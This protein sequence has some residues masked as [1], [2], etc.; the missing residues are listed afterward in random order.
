[1]MDPLCAALQGPWQLGHRTGWW[2]PVWLQPAVCH[3]AEQHCSHVPAAPVSEAWCS[4]RQ[5]PGSGLQ[6]C[7]PQVSS[8]AAAAVQQYSNSRQARLPTDCHS[9]VC[10]HSLA[11]KISRGQQYANSILPLLPFMG[12]VGS[13]LACCL[14]CC[15]CTIPFSYSSSHKHFRTLEAA[16]I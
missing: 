11:L 5:G 3:P 6:A 1:M 9:T 4:I 13:Q 10:C 12:S 15:E 14:H 2:F 16:S 8:R 7:I